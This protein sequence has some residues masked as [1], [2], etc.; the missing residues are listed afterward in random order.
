MIKKD[1]CPNCNKNTV[2]WSNDWQHCAYILSRGVFCWGENNYNENFEFDKLQISYNKEM[3][4]TTITVPGERRILA[5]II[6]Q[7]SPEQ[8]H[9]LIKFI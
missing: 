2:I 8:I 7:K 9:T 5:K 6:G 4:T 1:K 3:N